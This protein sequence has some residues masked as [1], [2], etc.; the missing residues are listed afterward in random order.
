MGLGCG[1]QPW[2]H[3]GE[4]AALLPAGPVGVSRGLGTQGP[5]ARGADLTFLAEGL[6]SPDF[7]AALGWRAFCF[8]LFLSSPF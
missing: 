3:P 6:C 2:A 4:G 8:F 5:G 7:Q 1:S